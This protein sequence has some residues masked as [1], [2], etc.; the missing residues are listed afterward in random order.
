M[1]YE[2]EIKFPVADL[3]AVTEKLTAMGAEITGPEEEIDQYFA[4]PARDFAKS[5]EALRL[6][7]KG[8]AC[9]VTY[10]GPKLDATTK[11]RREI[12]LPLPPEPE[13][14][15]AW[16]ALLEA[17]GFRPVGEVRKSRSKAF[18][19]WEGRR[20]EVSLD[21]IRQ[22]GQFVELEL[23]TDRDGIEAARSSL[24]A[25][26]RA[27]GLSASERRSYLELLLSQGGSC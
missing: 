23:V 24:F 10:K 2:V 18:P 22:L 7:R 9:F 13:P 16:T 20:V 15:A 25:L 26:A 8:S 11:T 12:E 1:S 5:D 27:L 17:L 6:R 19:V 4:H 14:I 21:E 3:A